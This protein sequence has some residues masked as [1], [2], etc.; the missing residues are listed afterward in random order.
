MAVLATAFALACGVRA[1]GAEPDARPVIVIVEGDAGAWSSELRAAIARELHTE[2]V[3]PDD[4]KARDARGTVT[5]SLSTANEELVVRYRPVQGSEISR[6]VRVPED[7]PRVVRASALL[8][9]NLVRNEAEEILAAARRRGAPGTDAASSSDPN[10]LPLP[11]P[12]EGAE[13]ASTAEVPKTEV[14]KTEVP[15]T[16]EKAASQPEPPKARDERPCLKLRASAPFHPIVFSVFPPIATNFRAPKTRTPLAL[17][18]LYSDVG[19]I[20]GADIGLASHVDCDVQGAQVQLAVADTGGNVKGVQIAGAWASTRETVMGLQGAI[21]ATR[22]MRIEGAQVA[23]V[24]AAGDVRGVQLGLVTYAR[25][26]EG[27]QAGFVNIAS[28]VDGGVQLGLVNVGRKLK[29]VNIGLVTIA[30]ELDGPSFSLIQIAKNGYV[31]PIVWAGSSTYLNVNVGVRFDT[32]WTYGQVSIG[33][34]EGSGFDD[35]AQSNLFG[36][37]VLKPDEPGFLMDFEIGNQFRTGQND[38]EDKNRGLVHAIAGWRIAKRLA[39]FA[40]MGIVYSQRKKDDFV[41]PD[42]IAGAIF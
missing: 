40:G 23:L 3:A 11:S 19:H 24:G 20:Q 16:E 27:V 12:A 25:S 7:R 1:F 17:N 32:R 10:T 9:G 41:G 2:A 6:R 30:E 22:A 33:Y 15:K 26:V 8:T 21:G 36:V 31:R 37:H 29:G 18:L 5:L 13:T 4:P 28:N 14:P 42:V 34:V 35:V 39:F 38:E